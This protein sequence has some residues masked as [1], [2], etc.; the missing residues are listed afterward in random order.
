[1]NKFQLNLKY[2]IF[3]GILLLV[4]MTLGFNLFYS[5]NLFKSDKKAYIFEN[6]LKRASTL[7]DQISAELI[8][9]KRTTKI[10]AIANESNSNDL[11]NQLSESLAIDFSFELLPDLEYLNFN[12]YNKNNFLVNKGATFAL[13]EILKS[14]IIKKEIALGEITL[15]DLYKNNYFFYAIKNKHNNNIFV[16]VIEASKILNLLNSDQVFKNSFYWKNS[17]KYKAVVQQDL[18]LDLIKILEK[19]E[20]GRGAKEETIRDADYILGFSKNSELGFAITSIIPQSAAFQITY[21]LILKTIIWAAVI[22]GLLTALGV[23]FTASIVKPINILTEAANKIANGELDVEIKLNSKDEFKTLANTFQ[24]M[25]SKIKSLLQAKQE[26]IKD[27]EI[28]SKNLANLNKNLEKIVLERTNELN[29]SNLFMKAMIDSLDQGLVVLDKDLKCNKIH[30]EATTQ[31]LQKNPDGLYFHELLDI[32]D[33]AEINSLKDW[34]MIVFNELLSFES[35][36]QLAPTNKTWGENFNDSGYKFVELAYFPMRNDN[37]KLESIVA[38]STDK[39]LEIQATEKF[40][41]SK[42]QFSMVTKILSNKKQFVSFLKEI[43]NIFIAISDALK[44]P[45]HDS[46]KKLMMLYHTLNGGFGLYRILDLQK[47]ARECEVSI[48]S[49]VTSASP[50]SEDLFIP[51]KSQYQEFIDSFEKRILEIERLLGSK[52]SGQVI[53]FEILENDLLKF[54]EK[55]KLTSNKEL[56]DLFDELFIKESIDDYL[57]GYSTFVETESEKI[58]K[59]IMP[60][61]IN[62]NEIKLHMK[63][64]QEFFSTLIHAFRNSLDHGIE[65]PEVRTSLSKSP[66]GTISIDA[67]LI[68]NHLV[69]KIID[70]G[71]GINTDRIKS[72]LQALNI[73]VE[74]LTENELLN[75]IFEPFFSTKDEVSALSGR[76]VGMSSIKDAVDKIGGKIEIFSQRNIGTIFTFKLPLLQS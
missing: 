24:F 70:N 16:S 33:E 32:K 18:T 26:I 76:G 1:M 11:Y 23:L 28:A 39:T 3:L 40:K 71:S 63:F 55:V 8:N 52:F 5:I 19:S 13:K 41:E 47:M 57:S 72:K 31:I 7:D 61:E 35:A 62:H 4:T 45:S 74:N 60:L 42:A 53:N 46:C 44:D 22:L 65:T 20:T 10:I 51:L 59:K 50:V 6:S 64:Y 68:E 27:L 14:L 12:I 17:Q 58:G 9:F 37:G 36:A 43:E 2:K 25:I 73:D 75:V 34:A 69:L 30:T 29:A 54:K 56:L 49:I 38:V 21:F 48:D 67:D 15:L 66:Q